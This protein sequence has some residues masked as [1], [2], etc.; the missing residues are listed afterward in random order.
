ML[1]SVGFWSYVHS[2][3][4]DSNS[5]IDA[6]RQKIAAA[7]RLISGKQASIW[8]DHADLKSGNLFHNE[9]EAS[10]AKS[11]FFIPILTPNYGGSAYCVKELRLFRERMKLLERDDLVFPI[12]YIP[13]RAGHPSIAAGT[14]VGNLL[15]NVHYDDFS[16]FRHRSDEHFVRAWVDGFVNNILDALAK[17]APPAELKTQSPAEKPDLPSDHT[18]DNSLIQMPQSW[19]M[20][21]EFDEIFEAKSRYFCERPELIQQISIWSTDP[22][23][24]AKM[25]LVTGKPG[26]GK[27][28]ISGHF[29]RSRPLGHVVAYYCFTHDKDH[30]RKLA[31]FARNLVYMFADTIPEYRQVLSTPK[32]SR[33]LKDMENP[34]CTDDYE[35]AKSFF[36][37]TVLAPLRD[38]PK[39]LALGD[40]PAWLVIDAFDE[41]VQDNKEKRYRL[42]DDMAVAFAQLPDWMLILATCR[43][44]SD[45]DKGD[46]AAKILS[47]DGQGKRWAREFDLGT[48]Q[49]KNDAMFESYID[50]RLGGAPMPDSARELLLKH[51]EGNFLRLEMTLDA[52]LR[53]DFDV[54]GKFDE[55]RIKS[56]PGGLTGIYYHTFERMFPNPELYLSD[57][58]PVISVIIA[59]RD[60]LTMDEQLAT[61]IG[62]PLQRL[63]QILTDASYYLSTSE[64]RF[65]AFHRSFEDFIISK[66]CSGQ[67][68][69]NVVD[70]D[71]I[72]AKYCIDIIRNTRFEMRKRNKTYFQSVLLDDKN[73]INLRYAVSFGIFH[74]IKAGLFSD[75]I[76]FLSFI[77]EHWD[78]SAP[79]AD[80][81]SG[82]NT[83]RISPRYFVRLL[84][85]ELE[86][87]PEQEYAKIDSILLAQ[88]LGDFYQLDAISTPVKIIIQDHFDKWDVNLAEFVRKDNFVLLFVIAEV[89]ADACLDKHHP[90]RI[91]DVKAYLTIGLADK[92]AEF[93]YRQLG[94]ATLGQIYGQDPSKIELDQLE[95]MGDSETYVGRTVLGD[96]LI[97][98]RLQN[99]ELRRKDA[100]VVKSERFWNPVFDHNKLDVSM[101]NA[102]EAFSKGDRA[103]AGLDE[104]SAEALVALLEA[105]KLR[106]QLE[107]DPAIRN[108]FVMIHALLKGYFGL[109]K[110]P[111]KISDAKDDLLTCPDLCDLMRLFFS[112]PLW[113]VAEIAS[114]V[115]TSAIEEDKEKHLPILHKLL[116]PN[117][118]VSWRI[119]FGAI[120]TAYQLAHFDGMTAFRG[121][122]HA[123]YSH[124]NSRVRALCAEN[125]IAH[126]LECSDITRTEFLQQFNKEIVFW[127]QDDDCWVLEHVGRLL[128]RLSERNGPDFLDHEFIRNDAPHLLE[129]IALSE[130][131]GLTREQFLMQIENRKRALV[132]FS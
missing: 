120:E 56:L 111:Q 39:P 45:G 55:D 68:S 18:L 10:I 118:T 30:T 105:D 15:E 21:K 17:S 19:L 66:Q 42:F 75:A 27:S 94:A 36:A 97:N 9:I 78:D 7:F 119:R 116:D 65:K 125:L 26:T 29:V 51:C 48:T 85:L 121:A 92:E 25:A 115:L 44:G 64:N 1:G 131:G 63:E 5:S 22:R 91:E 37:N 73:G 114:S 82:T 60:F 16:T 104:G 108:R 101:L 31:S 126:I 113:N 24:N 57:V 86:N 38:L 6:L 59:Q 88:M 2:D 112:H 110:A 62:L 23:K 107:A 77:V 109:G 72:L 84:L 132:S 69:A 93:N 103:G 28:A 14:P 74:M 70:G 99:F 87:C 71:K 89:L 80:T 117:E 3:N 13:I 106:L 124:E 20:A 41:A 33:Q 40:K 67:Y 127:V 100:F 43:K 61:A 11:N 49:I 79:E 34:A 122:V 130:L 52:I 8:Y 47:A 76:G 90:A 98:L 35:A 102:I 81:R 53:G 128:R 12:V 96:L 54:N 4:E 58:K 123:F 95:A 50:R 83:N 129:G 32:I 46:L